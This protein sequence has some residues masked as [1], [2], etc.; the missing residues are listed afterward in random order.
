MYNLRKGFILM[1]KTKPQRGAPKKEQL[2]EHLKANLTPTEINQAE[3]LVKQFNPS[4]ILLAF[5]LLPKCKSEHC[6]RI[7]KSKD[8]EHCYTC[9]SHKALDS[10]FVPDADGGADGGLEL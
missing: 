8:S 9:R 5:R 10:L 1:T 3:L 7:L 6:S 2:L 4:I